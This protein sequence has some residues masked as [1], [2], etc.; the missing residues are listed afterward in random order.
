MAKS[1]TREAVSNAATN[2]NVKSRNVIWNLLQNLDRAGRVSFAHMASKTSLSRPFLRMAELSNKK[3]DKVML[4][5][6][7]DHGKGVLIN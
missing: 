4:V 3:E 5:F 2:S 6:L 7:R 1:I